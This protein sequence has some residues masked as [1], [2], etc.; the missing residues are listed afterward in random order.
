[1]AVVVPLTTPT[2]E[3]MFIGGEWVD[4][5][6]GRTFEVET[7][8]QRGKVVAHVPRSGAAD[9]DRAVRAAAAAFPSW[10]AV[11]ARDRGRALLRI[12]EDVE[13]KVEDP[14]RTLATETGKAIRRLAADRIV[15]VTLELGGKSPQILFPDAVSDRTVDG[16]IAGMRFARQGQSCTAG[17]R[18]F[19]HKS[20]Y[21]GFLD[22]LATKLATFKVGDPLDERNDMGAIISA[23]Q[24]DKVTSYIDDGARQDGART[25]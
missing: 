12:A 22:R 1:M 11:P 3:R 15:P 8:A 14:A 19:L 9:V 18:L 25:V 16:V 23:Q 20:V 24:F 2:R 10:R 5:A 21:D 13:A 4:S 17:S 6:D 7:P